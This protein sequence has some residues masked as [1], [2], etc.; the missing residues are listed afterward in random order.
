MKTNPK[1]TPWFTKGEKPVHIGVYNV[2]CRKHDQTG[3]WYS[4]WNGK[5]FSYW[6]R[7]IEAAYTMFLRDTVYY[8]NEK[9]HGVV[10]QVIHRLHNNLLLNKNKRY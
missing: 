2:S 10:L 6:C 1:L 3:N 9:A 4:Y 8:R 7:S 5:E